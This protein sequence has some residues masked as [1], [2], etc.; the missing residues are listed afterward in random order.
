MDLENWK[1]Q[2]DQQVQLCIIFRLQKTAL[3]LRA[4]HAPFLL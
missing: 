4:K 1:K 2:A 3:N